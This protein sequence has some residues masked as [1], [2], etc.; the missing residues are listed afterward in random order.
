MNNQQ[1]QASILDKTI[2]AGKWSALGMIVQK[3][4]GLGSF[5]ILARILAPKDYGVITIVLMLVGVLDTVSTPGFGQA[6]IQKKE[7]IQKYLNVFWTFN[8]FRSF[9]LFFI[10]FWG[11]PLIADFFRLEPVAISVLRWGGLIVIIQA[12]GNLGS[13]FFFKELDF[14]KLFFRD[15]GG[16]IA[17]SIVAIGWALKSPSAVA[18]LL[19]YFAQNIVSVILQYYFHPH[20]PKF[21]FYFNRLRDLASYG[22]WAMGQN[23]LKQANSILETV[24]VGRFLGASDLGLYS[25]ATSISSLPSSALLSIIY[26]VGFPAYSKVQDSMQKIMSG[27]LK[28]FDIVLAVTIPFLFLIIVEVERLVQVLLGEKWLGMVGAMKILVIALTLKGFSYIAY[29]LLEGVGRPDVRFK[30][31]LLQFFLA[32]PLILWLANVYGIQGAAA[33]I[34]ISSAIVFLVAAYWSIK[35]LKLRFAHLKNSLFT[36]FGAVLAMFLVAAPF[37][38]FAGPLNVFYFILFI[39]LLVLTYSGS[40]LFIGSYFDTGPYQTLKI[41]LKTI[42]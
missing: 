32:V 36:V 2:N 9:A 6:L 29:P 37:Y 20:R 19:G 11:A 41:I 30:I 18:L 27:F 17:F 13:L 28:S 23:I 21:S 3:V 35:Y 31:S 16:Q 22:A 40:L 33:A 12:F 14:K 4:V 39:S 38:I 15:V 7:A 26:K 1:N 24:V 42:L 5:F 10:I 25:R 8:F 34:L